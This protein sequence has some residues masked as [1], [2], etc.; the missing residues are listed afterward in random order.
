MSDYQ[1]RPHI[2]QPSIAPDYSA[3]NWHF[4]LW[5]L[6]AAAAIFGLFALMFFADGG[7][8]LDGDRAP[9]VTPAAPISAPDAT[10]APLPTLLD[11]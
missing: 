11:E 5:L 9:V 7:V 10:P 4:G 8:S 1:L 3:G 2:N 6:V